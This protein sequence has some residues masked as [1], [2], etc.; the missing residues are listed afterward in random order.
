MNRGRRDRLVVCRRN[1]RTF[2]RRSG[3]PIAVTIATLCVVATATL[4]LAQT[5]SA[6]ITF[7]V[8][9]D[10]PDGTYVSYY[11]DI[12][13]HT[14][15][16]GEDWASYVD[17][18]ASASLEVEIRFDPLLETATGASTVSV[19]LENNGTYNIFDFGAAHEIIVGTD[20][21]G[22]DADVSI[23]L[24]TDYLQNEL[25]FDTD[26]FNRTEDV[27]AN[28]TEAYSVFTHEL[29]HAFG[30]NGWRDSFDGSLP[31]DFAAP[32]DVLTTF[33]GE[34]LFFDGPEAV[35]IYGAAVP[36]TFGNN[37]HIGNRSPRPGS[38]LIGD[39]MNGVETLRGIRYPITPLDVAILSDT[40]LPL[41]VSSL[42]PADFDKDGDVDGDDLAIWSAVVG[43]GADADADQDGDSDGHD[44]LIWQREFAPPGVGASA[45]A[46]AVPEPTGLIY[47]FIGMPAVLSRSRRADA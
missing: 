44:Y 43:S 7:S 1:R 36:L 29:A 6:A 41:I 28:K 26:P 25:W 3:K 21:N 11:E 23:V 42:S 17:P 10:D 35:Q 5:V 39:L 14:L 18:T 34:N 22:V 40:G 27:P 30:I 46:A 12:R 32:F 37:F 33:D 2:A 4:L 16:A 47:L 24:G 15:A 20:P 31:G 45:G 38:D 9:F 13:L 19:F 8:S